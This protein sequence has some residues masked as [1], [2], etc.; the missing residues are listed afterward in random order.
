[1]W[2]YNILGDDEGSI[3]HL[4]R[5]DPIS[6]ESNLLTV[7]LVA[8]KRGNYDPNL[9]VKRNEW[10]RFIEYFGQNIEADPSRVEKKNVYF[11]HI[12][13]MPIPSSI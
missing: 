10:R 8:L 11:V 4:L 7:K 9:T 1:M 5:L 6:T 12:G 3:S 13:Y 2:W